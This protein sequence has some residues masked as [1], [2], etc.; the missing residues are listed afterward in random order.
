MT[1][2]AFQAAG[3]DGKKAFQTPQ[4]AF[5]ALTRNHRRPDDRQFYRC[6]WCGKF[7]IG[8]RAE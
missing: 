6:E 5:K 3:C 4:L 2:L 7:H 1:A 8:G